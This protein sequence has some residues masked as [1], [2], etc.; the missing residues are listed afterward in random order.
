[1]RIEGL[2]TVL[3]AVLPGRGAPPV[4]T[5]EEGLGVH[6]PWIENEFAE[7]LAETPEIACTQRPQRSRSR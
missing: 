5:A 6:T 4:F 3:P 2:P 7:H 1:M